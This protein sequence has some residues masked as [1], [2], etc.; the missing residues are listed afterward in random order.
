[1]RIKN[2]NVNKTVNK[3]I[4]ETTEKWKTTYLVENGAKNWLSIGLK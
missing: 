2:D 1:M 4:L 3:Q